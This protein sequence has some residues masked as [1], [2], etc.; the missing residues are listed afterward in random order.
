MATGVAGEKLLLSQGGG[1]HKA[2]LTQHR[3]TEWFVLEGTSHPSGLI[4]CLGRAATDRPLRASLNLASSVLIKQTTNP[5]KY[6]PRL[7]RHS[8]HLLHS[9]LQS[10]EC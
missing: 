3:M 6:N 9:G 5:P 8:L 4:S 1:L 7:P 2:P 10:A